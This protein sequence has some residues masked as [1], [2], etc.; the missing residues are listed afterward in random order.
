MTAEVINSASGGTPVAPLSTLDP[1]RYW[2][3]S[4]SA[5]LNSGARIRLA[6]EADDNVFDTATARVGQSSTSS[7]NYS[8]IGGSVTG[9]TA[10]GTIISTTNLSPGNDFFTIA[11]ES[12]LPTAWDGGAATSNWGDAANWSNDTVPDSTT[13]VSLT[14]G[15]PTT[16][17]VNGTFS[18]KNLTIGSN[19]TL[20]FGSGTLNVGGNYIQSNGSAEYQYRQLERDRNVQ[21]QRRK[22]KR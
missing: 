9:T 13:D 11:N 20:N 22:H 15:S 10:S 8:S 14:F 12:A 2:Q 19:T 7:G 4:N 16:I 5:A 18:V 1:A 21:P 6:Y 17:D 3:L